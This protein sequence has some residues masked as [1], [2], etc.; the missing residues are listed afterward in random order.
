MNDCKCGIVLFCACNRKSFDQLTKEKATCFE[1]G[2]NG[3]IRIYEEGETNN[4]KC[5]S[6]ID[7]LQQRNDVKP[8]DKP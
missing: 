1:Y 3:F 4:C 2:M 7:I 5:Q 6:C 8:E